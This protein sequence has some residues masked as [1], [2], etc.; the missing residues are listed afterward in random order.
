[1]Q[2][3]NAISNYLNHKNPQLSL[4]GLNKNAQFVAFLKQMLDSNPK[5]RLSPDTLE[6]DKF[7]QGVEI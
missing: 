7:M 2:N 1:M 5:M 4:A 3:Q 6:N